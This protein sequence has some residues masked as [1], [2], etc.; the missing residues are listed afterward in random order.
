M[1][2]TKPANDTVLNLR[3]PRTTQDQLRAIKE[4]DGIPV[5]EQLRRA[6]A[7]WIATKQQKGRK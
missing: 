4:R 1:S 3:L 7:L 5:S 6:L 2:T